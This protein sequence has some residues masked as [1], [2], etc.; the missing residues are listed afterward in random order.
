MNI[1]VRLGLNI[2]SI[3]LSIS[4]Y[5][6]VHV[7]Q[8][9]MITGVIVCCIFPVTDT[10]LMLTN[11]NWP[12][13]FLKMER[14]PP[15][16]IVAHSTSLASSFFPPQYPALTQQHSQSCL[17]SVFWPTQISLSAW[18]LHSLKDLLS[19]AVKSSC[20]IDTTKITY[21]K[22]PVQ[23]ANRGCRATL[24]LATLPLFNEMKGQWLSRHLSYEASG[25][26]ECRAA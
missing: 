25:P 26:A 8:L 1:I 9:A 7:Y 4:W 6:S 13:Y 20:D 18:S 3:C 23:C 21:W 15:D 11:Q 17:T 22:L 12:N 10:I 24:L 2:L 16:F 19:S 5:L 14:C